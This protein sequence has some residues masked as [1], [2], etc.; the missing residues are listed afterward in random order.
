METQKTVAEWETS[1]FGRFGVRGSNARHAAR[2]NCEMGE[3]LEALTSDD[4]NPKAA[5]EIAYVI[6]MLYGLAERLGVDALEE[7]DKKMSINRSRGWELDG[8][9]HGQH[10]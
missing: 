7:V 8:T 10:V 2:T 6:I 3:L 5:E 9:G 1:V 4:N